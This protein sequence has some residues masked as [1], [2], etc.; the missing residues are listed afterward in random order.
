MDWCRLLQL[1]RDYWCCILVSGTSP[2]SHAQVPTAPRMGFA[3]QPNSNTTTVFA[4]EMS[5][6]R[7][8]NREVHTAALLAGT[9]VRVIE[10]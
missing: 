4:N 10:P 2:K 6:E 7:G 9:A 8:P 5:L 1:F 3:L